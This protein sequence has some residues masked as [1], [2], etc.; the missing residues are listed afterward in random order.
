MSKTP[1]RAAGR[2]RSEDSVAALLDAAYWRM[3]DLGYDALTVDA[4]AKAAGAGKQTLYRRWPNKAA[5]VI[6]G[7][8]AKASQRIDRPRE[9]AIRAADLVA[10]LKAEFAALKPLAPS[11]PALFVD[12]F[13]EPQTAEAFRA[14]F[15]RPRQTALRQILAAL[16]A[17]AEL[18]DALAEAIDGAIW[19]RL[20]LG[21]KLDD[22]LA[23][24]LAALAR[25]HG[26]RGAGA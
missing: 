15:L 3:L 7:V 4:I 17:D 12:A 20:F 8:A 16:S 22:G 11:L 14:V 25:P 1:R 2:P 10:F 9:T 24:R 13:A 26:E 5:L 6:E 19:R 21:E 23:R 18:R